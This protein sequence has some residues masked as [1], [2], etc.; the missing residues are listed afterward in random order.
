MARGRCEE[1]E[2]G[3]EGY[4]KRVGVGGGA[5]AVG[6]GGTAGGEPAS[7]GAES[8]KLGQSAAEAGEIGSEVRL[9][10]HVPRVAVGGTGAA[11]EVRGGDQRVTETVGSKWAGGRRE[12]GRLETTS[13]RRHNP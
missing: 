13:D 4:G 7:H 5:A 1:D 2:E 3:G 8:A 12:A 11:G 10:R 9:G 6:G